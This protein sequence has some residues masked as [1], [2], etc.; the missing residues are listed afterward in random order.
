MNRYAI[1]G[2]NAGLFAL[3]CFLIA[4]VIAE[5]GAA[6]LAPEPTAGVPTAGEGQAPRRA[7]PDR[8]RILE[9]NLF[10][11][12]EVAEVVPEA[13]LEDEELAAT[14]LPLKL[15]GTAASPDA[16]LAFAAIDDLQ[17]RKHRVLT[18]GGEIAGATVVRIERKRVVLRNQG[19]LE[20]LTLADQATPSQVAAQRPTR[21]QRPTPVARRED[22][23]ARVRQV[24]ENRFEVD[25]Q[26]VQETV[27]NPAA[28]FSE[29]RILP[30][31]EEGEMVGIQLN[32]IKEGSLFQ[33]VGLQNG[34]TI[35]EFNGQS[36]GTP[37]D[38]AQFLQKLIDGQSFQV[39]VRGEDGA[40]RTLSFEAS[41]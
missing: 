15:L 33:E 41:P 9:R 27:R 12:A 16:T 3:C 17:L 20:E 25:S 8:G 31:Y 32:A 11:S 6:R 23:A 4:G 2:I 39:L 22:L 36:L 19:K 34:D 13:V 29:A 1:W 24:A 14:A 21:T 5:V 38:S 40:E 30:R 18:T 7:R 28:L 37:A 26:D 10:A 35:V